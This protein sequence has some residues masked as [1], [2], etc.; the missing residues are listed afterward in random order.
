MSS[1]TKECGIWGVLV[2]CR[3]GVSSLEYGVKCGVGSV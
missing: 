3:V 1:V 2:Q